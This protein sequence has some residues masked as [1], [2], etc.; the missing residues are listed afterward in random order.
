MSI[1]TELKAINAPIDNHYSDLYV[2]I[3]NETSKI[4]EKYGFKNNVTR[5]RSN[6]T[7]QMWYDIPFA[8]DPY[9]EKRTR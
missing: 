9:W 2:R 6:L 4:I 5:F 3:T 1:Y 7:G 8:F